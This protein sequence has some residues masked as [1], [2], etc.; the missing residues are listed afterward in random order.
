MTT[1]QPQTRVF[2]PTGNVTHCNTSVWTTSICNPSHCTFF[3]GANVLTLLSRIIIIVW[4]AH[5]T[6]MLPRL[7][8]KVL[9]NGKLLFSSLATMFCGELVAM[10]ILCA[11]HAGNYR[12]SPFNGS[13]NVDTKW[14]INELPTSTNVVSDQI[15]WWLWPWANIREVVESQCHNWSWKGTYHSDIPA[16]RHLW[17]WYGT[18]LRQYLKRGLVCD[19]RCHFASGLENLDHW[20]KFPSSLDTWTLFVSTVADYYKVSLLLL[21]ARHLTFELHMVGHNFFFFPFLPSTFMMSNFRW[22]VWFWWRHNQIYTIHAFL[23]FQFNEDFFSF[24]KVGTC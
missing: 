17:R 10:I 14:L 21:H 15:L 5:A 19:R 16:A 23:I 2:D 1:I 7:G 6:I 20:T 22:R 13:Y 24:V 12:L 8:S 3:V 11:L 4:A 18:G 9:Q